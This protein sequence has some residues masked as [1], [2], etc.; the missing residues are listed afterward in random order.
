MPHI[1]VLDHTGLE[2]AVEVV[3]I[4]PAAA[5][6]HMHFAVVDQPLVDDPDHTQI[7]VG[8]D[9]IQTEERHIGLAV[10]VVLDRRKDSSFAA[11][12]H[13]LPVLSTLKDSAVL[14]HTG[15]VRPAVKLDTADLAA[16]D[17]T[18]IAVVVEHS[19][20]AVGRMSSVVADHTHSLQPVQVR[21]RQQRAV[22]VHLL[23]FLMLDPCCNKS[24]IFL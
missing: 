10:E 19:Q 12:L 20:M 22:L 9:R 16:A 15:S 6:G 23:G 5:A 17:H 1:A 8:P 21:L 2:A 18:T 4:H 24:D 14:L 7:V 11:K 3:H 13:N